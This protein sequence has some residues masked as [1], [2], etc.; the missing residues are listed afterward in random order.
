MAK[1][2][3]E[4]GTHSKQAEKSGSLTLEDFIRAFSNVAVITYKQLPDDSPVY[5][6]IG[7]VAAE[8]SRLEHHLD[9]G[10]WRLSGLQGEVA[11][12]LT[13][14]I[15]GH[16][17]KCA[18]LIGLAQSQKMSETIIKKIKKLQ[19]SLF[20][21][22]DP[23]NRAVHDYWVS[24]RINSTKGVFEGAGRFKSMSRKEMKYGAEI[25]DPNF[26]KSTIDR[27]QRRRNELLEINAEI[28]KELAARE[29]RR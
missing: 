21:A 19:D 8:W 2:S 7:R 15:S 17:N 22:S 4:I 27:I 18:T 3:K 10:I 5:A 29:K 26:F 12:C 14:Q 25:E 11:A 9:Q 13:A 6:S 16:N 28:S 23:R 1:K 24:T 20:R